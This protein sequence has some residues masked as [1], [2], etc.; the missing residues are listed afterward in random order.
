M[1]LELKAL[2]TELLYKYNKSSNTRFFENNIQE[3]KS[4]FSLYI[5]YNCFYPGIFMFGT[6]SVSC[7]LLEKLI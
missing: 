4:S 1:V 3:H 2:K 5:I 7:P 6:D